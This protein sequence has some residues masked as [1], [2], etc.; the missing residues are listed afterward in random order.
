MERTR[1]VRGELKGIAG[2]LQQSRDPGSNRGP[3]GYN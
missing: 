2:R 1:F 3:L